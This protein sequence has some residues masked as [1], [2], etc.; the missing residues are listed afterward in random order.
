MWNW[1]D[2][3]GALRKK[4][5]PFVVVT[6]TVNSGSTPREVGA[7]MVVCA[8][9]SFFGTIGGGR[10]EELAI[11]DANAALEEGVSRSIRYPL[12]K[13][14]KQCCG[15]SVELFMEVLNSGPHLYIFG[16]GH[17]GEAI[18]QTL[19]GTP[20]TLHLIDS[21]ESCFTPG[22]ISTDVIQHHQPWEDFVAEAEWLENRTYAVILTH[23]HQ[24]DLE[25]LEA[26]LQKPLCYL[27][28][29]GS[30]SK[31]SHFQQRL[32]QNGVDPQWIDKVKCP[33]GIDTGGKAPKE[34]A[35]SL[36]AE[37][38]KTHYGK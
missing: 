1:I 22:R 37:L 23:S 3:V 38:L 7:K 5:E 21:R 17:V 19:T 34:V 20:F 14:T 32:L 11:S 4:G 36:G 25:I 29:I 31:W 33:I 15:G 9:N 18:C 12:N 8:D 16:G 2:K 35:I 24:T 27:G 13:V 26:L 6:L 28:L 30:K 10:L